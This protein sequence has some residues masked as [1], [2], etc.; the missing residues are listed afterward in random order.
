CGVALPGIYWPGRGVAWA[1]NLWGRQEVPLLAVLAP[2]LRWP[3]ALDSDRAAYVLGEQWKGVAQGSQ[4]V[5][6]L[7]AGTGIGAGILC[8]GRL[9]RGASGIAGAVGWFALTPE[10]KPVYA[11]RGC[12]EA[13]AAGPAVARRLGAPGA[14][15]VVQAARAGD[16]AALRALDETA[17]WL[18]MAVAN[19]ISALDPEIVVLGGG[20][21]SAG[22]LLLEPVR[23]E[24]RRWAQPVAAAR[25]RIEL[26][27]LGEDAGVIGAAR[28]AWGKAEGEDVC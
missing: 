6:Y 17:R 9:C 19:L 21:M 8:G 3:L 22:D 23:R 18:G 28:L 11:E 5:V 14:E 26:T 2:R 12:L 10:W 20:L 7:A 25:V 16:P 13:E 4:D 27:A 24:A 15:S 1:P